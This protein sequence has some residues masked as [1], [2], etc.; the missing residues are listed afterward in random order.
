[1]KKTICIALVFVLA[2]ASLAG[3]GA[4]KNLI[5]G[6]WSYQQTTI[7]NVV[8]ER[9][10]TFR[11]DGTGSAPV[12]DGITNVEMTYTLA[13]DQLTINRGELLDTLTGAEVYTVKFGVNTMTLTAADGT[14]IELTKVE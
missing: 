4:K 13:G 7:L 5:L 9:T 8:T 3:C 14:V 11:E 6:T 2:L 12:L 1:M 10:Y